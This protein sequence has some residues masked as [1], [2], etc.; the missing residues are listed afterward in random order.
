MLIHLHLVRRFTREK[1]I[2]VTSAIPR[3]EHRYS[4]ILLGNRE[5]DLP[6]PG[7]RRSQFFAFAPAPL[8]RRSVYPR[9]NTRRVLLHNFQVLR[10][11]SSETCAR[12]LSPGRRRFR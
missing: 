4:L 6:T 7:R 12:R 11:R 1:L 8:S 9:R 3:E 2:T 5:F 10:H